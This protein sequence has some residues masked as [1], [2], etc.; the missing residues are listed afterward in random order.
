MSH[1]LS[2]EVAQCN[3]QNAQLKTTFSSVVTSL[4][5]VITQLPIVHTPFE[6]NIHDVYYFCA[7]QS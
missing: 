6:A 7:N 1:R 3:A 5:I 4:L 2:S